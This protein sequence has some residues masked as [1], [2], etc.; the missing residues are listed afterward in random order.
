MKP[1]D[2]TPT[3]NRLRNAFPPT[4]QPLPTHPAPRD[5]PPPH[6]T[7]SPPSHPPPGPPNYSTPGEPVRPTTDPP[8]RFTSTPSGH[9]PSGEPV[10]PATGRFATGPP[11]HAAPASSSYSASGNPDRPATDPPGR[12]TSSPLG[13]AASGE[14]DS[15]ATGPP[16][17]F[18]A[19]PP[20]HSASG[21]PRTND[22]QGRLRTP[23]VTDM[24]EYSASPGAEQRASW[25]FDAA[26][27]SGRAG[28]S[29]YSPPAAA[30]RSEPDEPDRFTPGLP[31]TRVLLLVALAA[32]LLAAGY[33]WWSRPQPQAEPQAVVRP[34]P[35]P[36]S[37]S[38]AAAPSATPTANLVVDVAGKVKHPGVVTLPSGARVIDAIN[39][40][41]GIRSG[42]NT[43]TLNLARHITDGE[44]ILVGINATPG[45]TTPA[46]PGAPGVPGAPG[47]PA[48]GAQLDLNA[49]SPTQLDQLPGVG[50]VLAQRIVDYRTQHGA[51]RSIDELRQ[52]SGI[53]P[54]KFKDLQPLVRI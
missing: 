52:V 1:T 47:S 41:G 44:Q 10:R 22:A 17:R 38:V 29:A 27:P 11:G 26:L 5:R 12:F 46:M 6:P 23:D 20:G 43:G 36:H 33:L 53:G 21:P 48:P 25:G 42:T 51:F 32:A 15:P 3:L 9:A 31:G 54:A 8:G 34:A 39:Q 16:G 30:L 19:S 14:P 2:P 28:P 18:A 49:A 35:E 24:A 13:Y 7:A 50:P 40:A 45:P 4:A 37:A